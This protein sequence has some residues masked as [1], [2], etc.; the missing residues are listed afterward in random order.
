MN[1]TSRIPPSWLTRGP[2][3]LLWQLSRSVSAR[4]GAKVPHR[5]GLAQSRTERSEPAA[6]VNLR[7]A[8]GDVLMAFVR[9]R[10]R[11]RLGWGHEAKHGRRRPARRLCVCGPSRAGTR[12]AT[13]ES[14]AKR[15]RPRRR[16]DGRVL[17][18]ARDAQ[19]AWFLRK[20]TYRPSPAATAPATA[21]T[22]LI[23]STAPVSVVRPT[24]RTA[25]RTAATPAASSD[26]PTLLVRLV[27]IVVH[28]SLTPT[29]PSVHLT[30]TGPMGKGLGPTPSAHGRHHRCRSEKTDDRRNLPA[31]AAI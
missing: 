17:A 16:I 25:K 8:P 31:A 23:Q 19:T 14:L 21:V 9:C 11:L 5:R 26:S 15:G 30:R 4:R 2:H 20:M 24:R 28:S 7:T 12:S 6:V 10:A 3:P 27:S 18:P 29:S 22:T 13:R 1:R